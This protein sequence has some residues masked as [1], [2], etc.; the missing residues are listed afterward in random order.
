MDEEYYGETDDD[1]EEL[2]PESPT[3]M[4]NNSLD[5][6]VSSL[7]VVKREQNLE[8][9]TRWIQYKKSPVKMVENKFLTKELKPP[10]EP[11]QVDLLDLS[12]FDE[13]A[14]GKAKK[15]GTKSK[16]KKKSTRID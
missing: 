15:K 5:D 10:M 12:V 2:F 13:P 4:I 1:D 7:L 8:G 11:K 9:T 14:D 16:K 6:T 3:K